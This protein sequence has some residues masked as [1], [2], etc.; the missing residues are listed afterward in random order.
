MDIINSPV[1]CLKHDV[2]ETGFCFRFQVEPS[3]MGPI[4]IVS[5]DQQQHQ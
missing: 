3:Q 5:V 1:F 4:D 2:S